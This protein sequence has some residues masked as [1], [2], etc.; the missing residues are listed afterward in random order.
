MTLENILLKD[1]AAGSVAE[2]IPALGFNCH[3]FAAMHASRPVEVLYAAE[4]FARGTERASGSG[5]PI[6]FP[7]PGRIAGTT[8]VW[9]GKSY[10]LEAGDGRGNAIH[11]FVHTRPWRV[12]E[13]TP[14]RLVGQF[15]ASQDDPSL[16]G[17]WPSDFRITATYTLAGTS[18]AMHYL[19]ENCGDAPLPCGLGTH[20]YFRLPLGGSDAGACLVRLPVREWWEL[21]EMLPT[22]RKFPVDN[23]EQFAA[24][25]KFADMKFDDVFT[26]LTF[27]DGWCRPSIH[28]PSGATVTVA[29]DA[30]FR[31]CVVYTPPH[32]EAIC[33]EPYTCVAGAFVLAERGIDAGV[34][35]LPPGG[36]FEARVEFRVT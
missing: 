16:Q 33:I 8:F 7:F 1:D 2:I 28:D 15:H 12:L 4:N 36:S 30:A 17:R 31:A 20:P 29:F 14:T 27:A 18:L 5:T 3:R 32:R 34:R 24:G 6:L 10:P 26:E 35:V 13:Q 25:Q 19:C 11:G 21:A 23:A 22:G 9:E